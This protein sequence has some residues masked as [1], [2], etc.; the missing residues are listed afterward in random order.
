MLV[1]SLGAF[2]CLA[3]AVAA[4]IAPASASEA[5]PAHV[6]LPPPNLERKLELQRRKQQQPRSSITSNICQSF[7]DALPAAT[8]DNL[9][10]LIQSADYG[11]V[12]GLDR[13]DDARLQHAIATETNVVDVAGA[14]PQ[15][16]NEYDGSYASVRLLN[17]V[18]FLYAVEDIHFWCIQNGPV[19]GGSCRDTVWRTTASWDIDPGSAVHK[20]VAGAI[21]A[22]RNNSHF[23]DAGDDHADT[24]IEV[25]RVIRQ[26]RQSADHLEIALWWLNRWD[27]RYRTEMF[28][29]VMYAVFEILYWG[30]R[31]KRRFGPV[32]GENRE[33]LHALL[34]RALQRD[35]LGTDWQ[36]IATRSAVEIGR[37]SIYSDTSNYVQVREAVRKIRTAYEDDSAFRPIWLRV[38]AELDYND[39]H[40]CEHY[41]TC[42][43]YAGDGFTAKFRS[44]VFRQKLECPTNYCPNDR[45]TVH[46]QQ[47]DGK[48]LTYA[49][50]RLSEVSSTF[51]QLFD[52]NCEPVASDFN[53]HLDAYVFHDISSCED[54]SSA[55][56]F[57]NIDA[58]SGIYFEW[59]PAD[60]NT[61]PYFVVTE[62][63]PSESPPDPLLSIWNW[64]HEYVHYLDGRY[65]LYDGYRGDLDSLHWWTE[66]LANYLAAEVYRHLYQPPFET[67][68]T[69]AEILLH[70][71]SLATS[72]SYRQLAV[73][74]FM[75]NHR[76]FVDTIVGFM[77]R[78]EYDAYRAFLERE[79]GQYSDAWESWVRT[80]GATTTP[81]GPV[82]G[83][84]APDYLLPLFPAFKANS[85]HGFV[86]V[87]NLSDREGEVS[88][89]AVDDGGNVFE[90]VMLSLGARQTAHFNSEDFETGNSEKGLPQG[91][92]PG[93]GDWRLEM[94][95]ALDVIV[96]A[97]IRTPD[98]FVTPMGD[99]ADRQGRD[100]LVPFFNPAANKH[101]VSWLRI[102]NLGNSEA[103]VTIRGVDDRGLSSGNVTAR[104][105]GFASRTFSAEDLETGAE[106]LEGSLGRG[107]DKWR[108]FVSS[109]ESILVMSLLENPTGHLTNLSRLPP[110]EDVPWK[111]SR[112]L[113]QP[114]SPDQQPPS[115]IPGWDLSPFRR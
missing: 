29:H 73:R 33:L 31:D 107:N 68:Y 27:D 92:G 106:G 76:D 112:R 72:Y 77:R 58:C 94:R 34:D 56:F 54:Y 51:H 38:V 6:E 30:H 37:F 66:G 40:N 43:W 59:N 53:D 3:A 22:I 78:G 105:A 115:T 41:E 114:V 15:I 4:E 110:E 18:R 25:I 24:V 9:V 46:A 50:E 93:D 16:V 87:I 98:G 96:L 79:V 74:Y 7:Y 90:P 35:L 49:C 95:T 45:V 55:A 64:E 75:E 63:E 82:E 104:I 99:V 85:R 89:V 67:P 28:S 97:Y 102:G 108:L 23:G 100:Y 14:L 101:Q 2:L 42:D 70:S 60:R 81:V 84:D 111:E 12:V 5:K 80:G 47:L 52:T 71:D 11:C 113:F 8:G 103:E 20:A 13:V 109:P 1:L 69:L 32:F 86:R 61:T 57:R 26:Y 83:N 36:F 48:Q 88:I 62:Y 10:D 65:N 91:T 19:S 44:E 17:L 21:D 39:P